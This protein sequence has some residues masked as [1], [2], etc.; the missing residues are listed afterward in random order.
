[1]NGL[2]VMTWPNGMRYSGDFIKYMRTGYG[3]QI[4][5]NGD[6][7]EGYWKDNEKHGKGTITMNSAVNKYTS[8]WLNNIVDETKRKII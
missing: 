2:G 8:E 3:V 1:M 4:F 6:Q 5:E 7:Y